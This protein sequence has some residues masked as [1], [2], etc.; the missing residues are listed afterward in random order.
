MGC[1]FMSQW[2]IGMRRALV[3]MRV[4]ATQIPVPRPPVIEAARKRCLF[5]LDLVLRSSSAT[6]LIGTTATYYSSPLLRL[7]HIAVLQ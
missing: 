3:G 1:I 6:S 7:V 5:L 2:T 4:S